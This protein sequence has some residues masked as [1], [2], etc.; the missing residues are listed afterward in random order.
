MTLEQ[1]RHVALGEIDALIAERAA[2]QVQ[3]ER[4]L[5]E[6]VAVARRRRAQAEVVFLAVAQAERRVE[7]ADRVE[8]R[9]ADVE[10]EPDSRRQLRIR[11]H[12]RA[13]QRRDQGLL[14]QKRGSEQISALFENGVTV[15]IRAS[16]AAQRDSLSS[17]P[18]VTTVSEL[19]STTSASSRDSAMPRFAVSVKPRLVG[20]ASSV[21]C[22]NRRARNPEK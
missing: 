19:S 5:A 1:Q 21:T 12:C 13:L 9:A 16:D 6:H 15:P 3:H 22:G 8:Q 14:A 11:R 18:R 7:C 10:A 4:V 20:L 17:Q 2:A